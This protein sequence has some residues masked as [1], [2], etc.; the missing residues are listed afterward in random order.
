ML[1]TIIRYLSAAIILHGLVHVLRF[2]GV[3]VAQYLVV[4]DPR[5]RRILQ[6][7]LRPLVRNLI[8]GIFTNIALALFLRDTRGYKYERSVT[9]DLPVVATC[10]ECERGVEEKRRIYSRLVLSYRVIRTVWQDGEFYELNY[11]D[12]EEV[13]KEL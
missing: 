6:R 13:V 3:V 1:M 8:R 11:S 5:M 9:L 4:Q 2:W 12:D 10:D 7:R